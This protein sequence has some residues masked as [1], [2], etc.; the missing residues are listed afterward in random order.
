MKI[1]LIRHGYT[2]GNEKGIY[3]GRLDL[4]LSEEGIN[5]CKEVEVKLKQLNINA[6]YCSDLRRAIQS[7]EIIFPHEKLNVIEAIREIDFGLWEGLNYKQISVVYKKEFEQFIKDYV[8]FT[9][10]EGESFKQFYL[11]VEKWLSE[12]IKN[13]K[14][15]ETIAIVSH[16]GVIK[17]ILCILLGL[18]KEGFHSFDINSGCYSLI[19]VFDG[20]AV[21]KTL[22]K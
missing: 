1:I 20:I 18:G 4:N 8:N 22:N 21:L 10:P 17:A 13:H 16:G 12:T 19:E 9:F 5:Q 14:K 11:R 15:G 7:G 6:I 2:D 3:Q